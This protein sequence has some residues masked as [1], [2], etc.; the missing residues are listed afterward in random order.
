[1]STIRT[2]TIDNIKYTKELWKLSL[3]NPRRLNLPKMVE[4]EASKLEEIEVAK[5][6]KIEVS[7]PKKVDID[8]YLEVKEYI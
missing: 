3:L 2:H 6:K 1:M 5:H 7:R 4:I 8:S